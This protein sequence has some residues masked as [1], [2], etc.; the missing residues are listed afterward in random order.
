VLYVGSGMLNDRLQTHIYN[1]KRGYYEDTNKNIL[2]RIYNNG[3]LI[4]EVLK[5]SEN[6]STYLNGTQAEK[7]AILKSLETIEQ[8]YVDMYK[9]SI[10][11]RV[12]TITKY[13]TS[14]RKIVSY[15]RKNVNLGS[16]N[17]NRK[18][19]EALMA[20]ILWLKL[21]GYKNREIADLYQ[22]VSKTYIPLIGITKWIYLDPIKPDYIDKV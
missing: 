6:N 4:F 12:R 11:N 13:S 21:H 15:K 9:D 19:D 5:F 1:L 22:N 2:Q 17:P 10:C 7:E 20:N 3:E 16:K 18:Y 8:F 14:P